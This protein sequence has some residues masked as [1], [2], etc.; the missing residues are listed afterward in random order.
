MMGDLSFAR[1][2]RL[3]RRQQNNTTLRTSVG[4]ASRMIARRRMRDDSDPDTRANPLEAATA[5][6]SGVRCT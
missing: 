6:G 1:D 3:S 2:R 5:I 4:R